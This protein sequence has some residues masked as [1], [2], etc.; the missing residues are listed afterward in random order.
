MTTTPDAALVFPSEEWARALNQALSAD[1]GV[2]AALAEFGPFTAGAILEKGA[3][4]QSDFCVFI[5][6]APGREARLTFCEDE[7]ELDDL[8]P[9]YLATA[10]HALVRDLLRKALAGEVPDPL[11][12]LTSGKAKLKGDLARIV[13]VAGRHPNAGLSALRSLP[14]ATLAG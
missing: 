4:L 3:G 8:H 2:Q 13:K 6:A 1:A 14:T 11:Q 9:N 12:L 7:D 10:P 5:D